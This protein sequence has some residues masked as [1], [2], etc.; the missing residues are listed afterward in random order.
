MDS[1]PLWDAGRVEDTYKLR[2]HALCKALIVIALWQGWRL[3]AVGA[4][5]RAEL[6]AGSSLK[7]ALDLGWDDP[8]ARE[9]E[10][11]MVLAALE[12]VECCLAGRPDV[13]Q[14]SGVTASMEAARQI[15]AQDGEVAQDCSIRLCQ[16]VACVAHLP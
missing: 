5:A 4:E 10:L 14:T 15:R 9:T 2:G 1:I 11:G 7:A 16:G 12:A 3:A 8:A 13:S 6:V